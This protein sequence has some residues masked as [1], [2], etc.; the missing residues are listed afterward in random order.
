LSEQHR[1]EVGEVLL[2][3]GDEYSD[4]II[5]NTLRGG[6]ARRAVVG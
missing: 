5:G 3:M 4:Y 1:T 2:R 6:E